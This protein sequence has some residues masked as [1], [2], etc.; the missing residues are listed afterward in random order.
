MRLL[1]S[2]TALFL[3]L[4]LLQ[5]GSGGLIPLDA[6]SGLGLGFSKA[7][8]GLLGSAHFFGF[9]I[10]CWWAP[11]LMG[12]IGHS[13]AFAAFT[14][15][16]TIG[17]LAHMLVIDPLVWAGFR[18]MSGLCVAG[19]YT[20]IESW[21]QAKVT[22]ETRGR[23]F[24]VYRMVD[25]GASLAAQLFISVLEPGS[26]VS[27]NLLALLCC[28]AL[29]PLT[30]TRLKQPETPAAPRLRPMMAWQRS[31]LAAAG[32]VVSGLTASA[33][34][35]VGPVYGV[36][37]GLTA[38]QIALFLAAFVL[39]GALSQIP[40][41]W[42]ADKYDRRWV[43]IA[44]SAAGIAACAATVALSTG[45]TAA[46]MLGSALFGFATFP[47]Y[48]VS[49]AH[50]HDYADSSERVELSAALMFLYAVGAIASPFVVSELIAR[51]GP[52]AM[53]LFVSAAHAVL[54]V[55]GLQRMMRRPAKTRTPY[56]YSPRTT[57]VIGRLLGRSRDR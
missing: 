14:A 9:F 35:M 53:F 1:I 45:G 23:A 13:R 42:I 39:G 21:L 4:I 25:M 26:Y 48:S 34:R 30:I 17:I 27:Y 54:I 50:A 15:T 28:A 43:L 55:F 6:I 47:I 5:I 49:A 41:G 32:V 40:A 16:G 22:N 18:V 57:F 8:V 10:G 20:V 29:L 31:P 12:S 3:S 38:D 46:V 24:G 36:E 2:F 44:F 11:R 56:V 52:P 37:V 33:F 7:E 51:F 19:C